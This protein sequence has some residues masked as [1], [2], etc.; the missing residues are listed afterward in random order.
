MM[1]F[2][3][4]GQVNEGGVGECLKRVI[5]DRRSAMIGERVSLPATRPRWVVHLEAGTCR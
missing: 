2:N 3:H 4:G 5:V 1:E